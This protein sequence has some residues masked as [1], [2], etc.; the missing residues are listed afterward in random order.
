MITSK[1]ESDGDKRL[2]EG[3][4]LG[5]KMGLHQVVAVV[6]S[7]IKASLLNQFRKRIRESLY[8]ESNAVLI[9][10][11]DAVMYSRRW[12]IGEVGQIE[13]CAYTFCNT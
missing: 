13:M 5:T 7:A 11:L 12:A 10:I 2:I 4:I 6:H 3:A 1:S 8:V 9:P